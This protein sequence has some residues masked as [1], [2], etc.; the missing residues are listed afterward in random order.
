MARKRGSPVSA[1]GTRRHHEV[2]LVDVAVGRVARDDA[3]RVRR[4]PK[5]AAAP[6]L[7]V[8]VGPTPCTNP[9]PRWTAGLP[10]ASRFLRRGKPS[11]SV[12]ETARMQRIVAGQLCLRTA[13]FEVLRDDCWASGKTLGTPISL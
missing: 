2:E 10:G 7:D 8:E 3:G 4:V 6:L 1:R 12:P 13:C 11:C 5:F 9:L